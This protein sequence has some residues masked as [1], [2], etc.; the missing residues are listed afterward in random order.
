MLTRLR[1][2]AV[3]EWKDD[4]LQRLYEERVAERSDS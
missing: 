2:Q 1:A 3:I 4:A